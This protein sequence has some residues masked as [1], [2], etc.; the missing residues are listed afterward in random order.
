MEQ[1]EDHCI[2]CG[3]AILPQL[4]DLW[5]DRFG[6]PGHYTI[7]RCTVCDVEQTTPRLSAGALRDL[8]ERHY[9]FGSDK[10]A[11]SESYIQH[12]EA[13]LNSA[14]YCI[15]LMLDGDI[16]FYCRVA[17]HRAVS[18]RL[19]DVGCNEGRGLT[20]YRANG[21]EA[22]GIELNRVAAGTA[23]RRGFQVYIDDIE[24][25]KPGRPFD[26]IILS[27]VLEH[28]RDPHAMLRAA[29]R[30]LRSDGEVWISVPNGASLFRKIF[31]RRWINWHVPYHLTHFTPSTLSK[32]LDDER[33]GIRSIKTVTPSLWLVQGLLALMYA[34]PDKPTA[35]L[36]RIYLIAGGMLLLRLILFPFLSLANVMGRGDALLVRAYRIG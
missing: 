3:G 14:F 22:E 31:G 30:L 34:T 19:L 4:R 11:A 36:R 18:P 27:N 23:R 24:M 5:D 25:L 20:R 6:A 21:F 7:A 9:N 17:P 8:Y 29:R 28:A 12:R 16:S 32:L 26:V 1:L 10:T 15:W 13:L 2:L 35:Q 33:L